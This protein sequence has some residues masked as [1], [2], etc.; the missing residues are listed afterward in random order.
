MSGIQIRK[1]PWDDFSKGHTPENEIRMWDFYGVHLK[2]MVELSWS[3]AVWD[4]MSFTFPIWY[5]YR[6]NRFS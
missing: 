1:S 6:R 3:A 2:G 5:K 4:D